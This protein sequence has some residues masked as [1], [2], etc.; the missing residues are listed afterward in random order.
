MQPLLLDMP[1]FSDARGKF[2]KT[3]NDTTFKERGI[4]FTTKESYFSVSAADVIRGMHFHVPPHD[5]AKIVFCPYGAILDVLVDLRKESDTY[6]QLHSAVLSAANHR[7]FFV[8]SG[9]AHGFRSLE[10]Q[11]V[12]YYLVSG[13]YVA[14]ADGGIAFDSIGFDWD[15]A[16]PILSGRDTQFP[17][18]RDFKS[19]F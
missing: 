18:L 9:F 5:H 13:E 3:F 7:A 12:T 10:D 16:R 19:P 4:E 6:G 2:V 1:C 14:A 17:A 11:S 8:P 15:C